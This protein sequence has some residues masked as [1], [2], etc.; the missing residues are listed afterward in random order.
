MLALIGCNQFACISQI[1]DVIPHVV[2]RAPALPFHQVMFD[3]LLA[4]T[5]VHALL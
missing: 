1:L 5:A 2:T 4:S 3:T